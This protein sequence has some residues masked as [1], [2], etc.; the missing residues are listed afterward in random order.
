MIDCITIDLNQRDMGIE[1]NRDTYRNELRWNE[2]HL[3]KCNVQWQSG[4]FGQLL[5]YSNLSGYD[6]QN[7]FNSID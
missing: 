7:N 5:C 1:M 3:L 4:C 6:I 2:I